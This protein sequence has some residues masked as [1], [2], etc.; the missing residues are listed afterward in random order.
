MCMHEN[1]IKGLKLINFYLQEENH[2]ITID[3]DGSY[4]WKV[5]LANLSIYIYIYIYIDINARIICNVLHAYMHVYILIG[6]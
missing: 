5:L 6:L 4:I 3:N 1:Y 2:S